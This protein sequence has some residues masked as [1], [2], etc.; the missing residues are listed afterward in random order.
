MRVIRVAALGDLR[1]DLARPVLGMGT[2]DGVHLG[3]QAV[4]G[5]VRRRAGALGGVAGAL[6]F[7][8]HP[9]EVVRPGQAPPLLTPLPV[10]LA[11]LERLGMA[12]A[13]VIEFSRALADLTAEAF[14][15]RVLVEGLHVAEVCVGYD[16]GFGKGRQGTPELLTRLGA[17][18]GFAVEVVPPVSLDGVAVSSR[19]IRGLLAEGRV[20]EAQ[21]HLGRPYCMAGEVQSGAG[22]GRGLGFATANLPLPEPPPL[23]DGVYAGRV[24]VR[25]AFHDAMMNLGVAPTFGPGDRRLEI[26]L[27]G[28]EGALYGERVTAFFT[29]RL[30]DEQRFPDAAA[31]VAQLGADRAAAEAAWEAARGFPWPEWAL[32]A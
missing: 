28:W 26:H 22:R 9:L 13:V 32:Q 6:T 31:L 21:R 20:E 17:R 25:G 19:V 23:R 16:F 1:W 12:A 11:L 24:L 30:R 29:R 18:H 3:H 7:A 15:E 27:P 2:L 4:L 8:R 10:K 14:V 5:L